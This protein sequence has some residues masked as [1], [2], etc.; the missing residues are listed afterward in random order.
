M[1][2]PTLGVCVTMTSAAFGRRSGTG[3]PNSV[4]S[5]LHLH[6]P[7]RRLVAGTHGRSMFAFDLKPVGGVAAAA[8]SGRRSRPRC[9]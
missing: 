1:S 3:L 5:D 4:V 8:R 2:A 9:A 6:A 7:T